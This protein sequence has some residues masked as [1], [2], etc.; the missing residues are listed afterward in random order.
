MEIPEFIDTY[1]DDLIYLMEAGKV[2]LAHPF[3]AEV[4][5]LCDSPFCIYEN[6]FNELINIEDE[7]LEGEFLAFLIKKY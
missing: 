5:E 3:R 4:K 1:S 2:L 7:G 6:L